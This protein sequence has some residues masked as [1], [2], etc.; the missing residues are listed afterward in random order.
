MM[1]GID[2]LV[3]FVFLA[4]LVLLIGTPT[5]LL[6]FGIKRH[7][8]LH[9]LGAKVM[10]G[11]GMVIFLV[12]LSAIVAHVVAVGP[13]QSGILAKGISPDGSEYCVV[14]TYQP[15]GLIGEPY[16]VSFYM[17]DADRIWRRQYLAHQDNAWR[18]VAV[19]F[20]GGKVQV[21]HRGY[22]VRELSPP[23]GGIDTG[24]MHEGGDYLQAS[25]SAEDVMK[26]HNTRYTQW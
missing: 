15:L 8:R 7:R 24:T 6:V 2:W 26:W 18:D 16:Q 25:Y 4:V 10:I 17:R 23:T 5:C 11:T 9:S 3:L 14:Q 19:D 1:M 12:Y 22:P 20:N 21:S 13:Y